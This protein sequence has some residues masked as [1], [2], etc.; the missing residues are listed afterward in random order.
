MTGPR[1]LRFMV[2]EGRTAL[3]VAVEDTG[4][5]FVVTV[6]G[7]DR[8]HVGTVVLAQPRPSL[9]DPARLSATSTCVPLLGHQEEAL[10]RPVAEFLARAFGV[11]AA[12]V[13][14]VHLEGAR[15]EDLSAVTGLVPRLCEELARRI[16]EIH[17]E[18]Q[19]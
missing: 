1:S 16:H 4:Q 10:V 12:V 9:A 18:E 19:A 3:A 15:P 5:G 7:G 8:P 17:R 14:G 13:G 6:C 2:G 11:P